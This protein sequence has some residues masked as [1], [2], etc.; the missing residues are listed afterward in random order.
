MGWLAP[1]LQHRVD[2][3]L[4]WVKRLIKFA[5]IE[6]IAMELVKFDL[7]KQE[8]P[9]ITGAE[10]Q[11]GTLYGWELREYLLTKFNRTCQYCGAKDKPLEVEHIKPTPNPL[12]GGGKRVGF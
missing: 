1:S 5:P 4:N 7:Q 6:S 3:T 9:E 10:Y 2:T 8:D 11:H 12:P